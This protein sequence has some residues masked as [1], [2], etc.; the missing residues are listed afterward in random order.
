MV[1]RAV[2]GGDRTGQV[3]REKKLE[4]AE[5]IPDERGVTVLILGLEPSSASAAVPMA[6]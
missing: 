2:V 4:Y 5:E 3:R 6:R 1:R